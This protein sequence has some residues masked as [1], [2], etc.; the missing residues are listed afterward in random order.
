MLPVD[1]RSFGGR[2]NEDFPFAG[3]FQVELS[4][5]NSRNCGVLETHSRA[6]CAEV[7][8]GRLW[9]L[10]WGGGVFSVA[11]QEEEN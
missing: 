10:G 8:G 3:G 6:A 5:L 2:Y 11:E 9:C 1:E 7:K 4:Q